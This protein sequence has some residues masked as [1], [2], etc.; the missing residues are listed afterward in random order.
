MSPKQKPFTSESFSAH[1]ES[2]VAD[3]GITYMEALRAHIEENDMDEKT[4]AKLISP[5]IKE[6]LYRE[7]IGMNLFTKNDSSSLLPFFN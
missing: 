1:I 2:V 4:V 7:A 6:M 5:S 3:R